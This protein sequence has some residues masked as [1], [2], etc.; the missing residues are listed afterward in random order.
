MAKI[1]NPAKRPLTLNTGHVV[2]ADGEL[3]TTNDV[4]RCTDNAPTLG[5]LALS[6]QITLEYDEEIDPDGVAVPLT[7]I[8]ALPEA[9]AQ[10]EAD[11][12]LAV[13]AEENAAGLKA[14]AEKQEADAAPRKK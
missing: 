5:G 10:A 11:R 14:L 6:G 2:P 12:Q 1:I 13:A 9:A 3:K 4:L 8:E 7:V